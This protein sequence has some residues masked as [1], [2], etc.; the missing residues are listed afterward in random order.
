[1]L[2][3]EEITL[4]REMVEEYKEKKQELQTARMFAD[5]TKLLDKELAKIAKKREKAIAK[6]EKDDDIEK[7][8][9]LLEEQAQEA[10]A[11]ELEIMTWT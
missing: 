2:T 5:K 1:M 11:K 6:A 4:L 8:K 9:Q 10:K 3:E 7:K